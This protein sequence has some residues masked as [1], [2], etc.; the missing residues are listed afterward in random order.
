[1]AMKDSH[2]KVR[3]FM[4]AFNRIDALYVDS[5]QTFG[6]KGNL[7]VL[8]YAIADGKAYSQRQICDDWKLPR[9]TL[10]TIVRECVKDG[11]VELLPRGN[12]E[13]DIHLTPK[14]RK[15]ADEVFG[16]IFSAESRVMKPFL[17]AGALE[18][19]EKMADNFEAAFA[20]LRPRKR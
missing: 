2:E 15:I 16:P 14:G 13:K 8:F 11:L 7:F 10:N 1:M 17:K 9:T 3:R 20:K 12:K 5:V 6:V 19:M 4:I 18:M